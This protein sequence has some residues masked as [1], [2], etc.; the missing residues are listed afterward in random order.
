MSRRLIILGVMAVVVF[1]ACGVEGV[2][3][4]Q[5]YGWGKVK[6]PNNTLNQ[7]T[8]ISAGG[9]HSLVLKYDGSI[10]GWGYNDD[11]QATAPEGNDYI[12]IA[13]V[14]IFIKISIS[15]L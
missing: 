1:C 11:G 7:I 14:R 9:Y 15:P 6:L 12:A 2:E 8:K 10:V 13:K 4:G 3:Q 5:I